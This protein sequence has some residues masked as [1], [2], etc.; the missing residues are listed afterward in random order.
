MWSTYGFMLYILLC[1]FSKYGQGYRRP[2]AREFYDPRKPSNW[3]PKRMRARVQSRA[4][5]SN[6]YSLVPAGDGQYFKLAPISAPDDDFSSRDIIPTQQ[7][8]DIIKG[9]THTKY[10]SSRDII[11]TQQTNDIIK[12]SLV[13]AGD[14]QY[15]KLAPISAPDD[16]K[17]K[18]ISRSK[19]Q[20]R[21]LELRLRTTLEDLKASRELTDQLMKEREE[22]E[23]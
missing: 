12:Y 2:D 13:P 21:D 11:P 9:A 8:N 4:K 20:T 22:N 1:I 5:P 17:T 14:G 19:A 23:K 7:T 16:D 3:N 18:M 10:F 6:L 15:F